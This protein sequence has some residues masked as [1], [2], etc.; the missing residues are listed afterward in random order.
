MAIMASNRDATMIVCE[1]IRANRITITSKDLVIKDEDIENAIKKWRKWFYVNIY[2]TTP[3]KQ[4]KQE[5]KE[6]GNPSEILGF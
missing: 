1:L 6:A 2:D 5:A 4:M 3:D